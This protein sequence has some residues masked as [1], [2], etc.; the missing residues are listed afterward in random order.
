MGKRLEARMRIVF[1]NL[2]CN[3]FLVRT[4][5]KNLRRVKSFPKHKFILEYLC[6]H[7]Y[8][9]ANYID[10]RG[11]SFCRYH[12]VAEHRMLYRYFSHQREKEC[13]KVWKINGLD[14]RKIQILTK[15]EQLREG[16]IIICY[17]HFPASI[18]MNLQGYPQIVALLHFYGIS[19]ESRLLREIQ[20]VAC[21][22]ESVLPSYSA[23]WKKNF[24]WYK[25]DFFLLPF[26]YAQRFKV[27]TDYS[28]RKNK[29]MVIGTI[30]EYE[31]SEFREIIGTTIF[32]PLRYQIYNHKEELSGYLDSYQGIYN[33][34][35]IKKIRKDDNFAVTLYK[36]IFNFINI[37]NQK[38]YF[39][40]DVVEKFN[41]YRLFLCPEDAHFNPGVSFVEGMACGTA[42]IGIQNGIY[43]DYGM[44]EGRH[45]IGY[46][47]TLEDLKEKLIFWTS[48]SQEKQLREIAD[49]GMRFIR[50]NMNSDRVAQMFVQQCQKYAERQRQYE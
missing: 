29:A 14:S 45:Y 4:C 24:S 37:G 20:P 31:N 21:Y 46:D 23:M 25:G 43:E 49:N 38:Q 1:I 12:L 34:K 40:F 39:S 35:G 5:A 19:E 47:G 26:V 6:N 42:M 41:E 2:H 48:E 13:Q 11:S 22:A 7:G 10:E 27:K 16:D 36:K 8:E 17:L 30:T 28:E 3:D 50:D 18:A 44:I 33:E 32:Q 15:P 9:V